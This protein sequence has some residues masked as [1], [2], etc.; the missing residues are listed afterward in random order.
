MATKR[1]FVV[2]NGLVVTEGVTAASLDISGDVDVDGTLEADAMTLNG[3]AITTTA[4]LSTGIS[5]GNVLVANAN[6][7]DNDFLRVDGTSIEG[8]T[9]TEVRSDLGLATSATTDTTNASNIGSGTL[10]TGRLAAALT[11]QTSILNTSLVVGRDSTDQIKFSTNDQIIFRVGNADG[12]I[13]KAS[14]EIEAASLD[15]SGDVDVDGTLETDNLTVG[16]QQGTDGQVLTST[17]SGVAWED[18][19]GGGASALNDLTDVISNITNFTDSILISPDGAAPPHGTLDSAEGNI[20]IGKDVLSALTSAD[21]NIAIGYQAM[22]DATTGGNNIGIGVEALKE[23]ETTTGIVAIGYNAGKNATGTQNVFLG[24][25][26][27]KRASAG[28]SQSNVGIGYNA[29]Q[30]NF[31]NQNVV[32]GNQAGIYLTSASNTIVGNNAGRNLTSSYN[33]SLGSDSLNAATS[34]EDNVAIGYAALDTLSTGDNNTALGYKAGDAVNTGSNNILLGHQAG[35]NIT[36]GSNNL[37]IGSVDA[38]AV[39]ADS[40]IRIASGDGNVL[41]ISGDSNGIKA[42]KIKVVPITGT[43]QLTDAQSGSYVY[44]TGSGVPELPDTAELGQQYTIINNKGS[45]ITVGLGSNGS[46]GNN[47]L[48]GTA[49]VDDDKA[50]TFV[51]VET[52]MWFAIG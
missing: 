31:G 18:A 28:T 51:A 48:I 50:K 40:Q 35:D 16:G 24:Y 14:G 21:K 34:A 13:F 32:I 26:A 12:V 38:G 7:A 6:V 47:G 33:T 27:G 19:A 4:T 43:T 30:H 23:L 37:I 25:S 41:W 46:G 1:D 15:I 49:T 8:R 2:K 45:Q 22:Q 11:A 52:N 10:A 9:A 20:G 5:N 36:S 39:D 42:H 44:V 17:G 3:T 29:L